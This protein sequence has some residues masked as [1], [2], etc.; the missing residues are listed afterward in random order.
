MVRRIYLLL[1][2]C[3]LYLAGYSQCGKSYGV[4]VLTE[5]FGE[6]IS[7]L[8]PPLAK[9]ITNLQ[10]AYNTCPED[11]Y[12]TILKYTTGCYGKAWHTLTDHTGDKNGY[13]MLINCS[14]EPSDF[15]VQ[16][17]NGLC[18][19][20]TY[21]FSAYIVN[22]IQESGFIEPNVTFTVEK[23]DGTVLTSYQTGNIPVTNPVQWTK[24]SLDFTTPEG[25]NSVVL[26]MH[27]NVLGGN[28][29][30][31]ALD[32][33]EFVPVGPQTA[34]NVGG[35]VATALSFPCVGNLV[36]S[37]NVASC[38]VQTAYQWQV[39]TNDA[40]FLDIPGAI[41]PSDT[42]PPPATAGFY[43]YRV[44]VANATNIG[45]PACRVFSDTISV[46][47]FPNSGV[48]YNNTTTQTCQYVPY[49]LPSGRQLVM[50]GTYAD[51]VRTKEGC[52]S[53]IT[54]LNLT[55]IPQPTVANL[56]P[57]RDICY[58]DSLALNPGTFVSYLWQDGSTKPI[59]QAK[60]PGKYKVEV[61]DADG[62][63]SADSVFLT[64][65]YCSPI[66]PPNAFT[67]NGDGINDKWNILGL[68]YF[69]DCTVV[70]YNR[71]GQ[72]VF[73]SIGY[74]QPW[75]GTYG[76]HMLPVGT[77]YYVIN[78]KNNSPPVSGSVTV[79]R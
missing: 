11:G 73:R 61:T 49:V 69:L 10:Y 37:S 65:I 51:T 19:G 39:S 30:D 17:V 12:Y 56:G 1:G 20:S 23:T 43:Y 57:A 32:D 21:E 45:S 74:S 55:I 50:A 27:N 60:S 72:A 25:V 46:N 26:R 77:Y 13:Y 66:R 18:D 47:Y 54:A 71:A 75:D 52:D 15:F 4:P 40:V 29:N 38:Y 62:C 14:T 64:Q 70:V 24:Y 28:G 67:P 48:V 31:L 5:T 16:T 58:A 68:Q 78:L 8:G 41:Y 36:L 3:M 6:G 33:I 79:L 63:P 44:L 59:Y 35:A 34:L 53:I 9:G 2:F 7:N 22:M 76:G 42:V